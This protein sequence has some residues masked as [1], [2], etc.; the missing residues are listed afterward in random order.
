MSVVNSLTEGVT[1]RSFGS[2]KS[3]RRCLHAFL[4][5]HAVVRAFLYF[6]DEKYK[7]FFS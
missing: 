5:T 2:R 7:I 3:G 6:C 4:C 1:T